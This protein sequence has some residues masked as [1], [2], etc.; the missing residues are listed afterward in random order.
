MTRSFTDEPMVRNIGPENNHDGMQQIILDAGYCLIDSGNSTVNSDGFGTTTLNF[1][2]GAS[3]TKVVSKFNL[4]SLTRPGEKCLNARLEIWLP[5]PI[6]DDLVLSLHR[7]LKA[8]VRDEVTW[9]QAASGD[10]WDAAGLTAG[11]DYELTAEITDSIGDL[12][13]S[14][15]VTFDLTSWVNDVCNEA[16]DNFGFLMFMTH[17]G[18]ATQG[19]YGGGAPSQFRPRLIVETAIGDTFACEA[20]TQVSQVNQTTNYGTNSLIQVAD[21][22]GADNSV[23]SLFRFL[24]DQSQ[25]GMEIES[26]TLNLSVNT[27]STGTEV[28]VYPIL[29]PWVETEAT[30]IEASDGVNWATAG[31]AAGTDYDDTKRVEWFWT[32][33]SNDYVSVDIT[34][35]VKQWVTGV[36]DNNGLLVRY[37]HGTLGTKNVNSR[38]SAALDPYIDITYRT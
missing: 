13:G 26:A 34:D 3:T 20:D 28:G 9:E 21:P 5:E 23:H 29:V 2:S 31:L 18:D 32:N 6:D 19:V 1:S 25:P 8:F 14:P 33:S 16:A 17:S 12:R 24:V 15:V 27:A 10:N 36:L 37:E 22:F 11:V 35:I 4:N 38:E 30:W 7:L